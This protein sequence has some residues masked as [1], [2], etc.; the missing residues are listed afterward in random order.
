MGPRRSADHRR[1]N[2]DP[3]RLAAR[4]RST[5]ASARPK[6]A[7]MR[8]HQ[9][10]RAPSTWQA[11]RLLGHLVDTPKADSR[12]SSFG[13]ASR[14]PAYRRKNLPACGS[15]RR[16]VAHRPYRARSSL[17]RRRL[18]RQRRCC[19]AQRQALAGDGYR[20]AVELSRWVKKCWPQSCSCAVS[21]AAASN[22]V[23]PVRSP[24]I[25]PRRQRSRVVAVWQ[26]SS[27][28]DLR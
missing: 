26:A 22:R 24:D 1:N 4:A 9:N 17:H 27:F 20:Q 5:H 19:E 25:R 18:V 23:R 13:S 8:T 11:G 7:P 21:L 3:R 6:P 16:R 14:I 12:D 28:H 10:L 15:R 2:L